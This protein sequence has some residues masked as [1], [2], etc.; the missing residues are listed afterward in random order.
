MEIAQDITYLE[1]WAKAVADRY[2]AD[3]FR[4]GVLNGEYT[5]GMMICR[6]AQISRLSRQ[7][8]RFAVRCLPERT[9]SLKSSQNR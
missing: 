8:G 3:T 2:E 7:K 1:K 5:D 9:E 4:L 6:Y